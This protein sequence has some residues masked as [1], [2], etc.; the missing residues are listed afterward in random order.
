ME[1]ST[2]SL[3]R[4]LIL[5]P[6]LAPKGLDSLVP[7]YKAFMTI[8]SMLAL[9]MVL[10][11]SVFRLHGK[12]RIS[13]PYFGLIS[14]FLVA[15]VVSAFSAKGI[16]NGLQELFFFPAAF[17]YLIELDQ[18]EFR[19]YCVASAYILC[20]LFLAE[21]VVPASLFAGKY[22]LTFLGHVQVFSQYGLLAFTLACFIYLKNWASSFV[23][24]ILATLGLISMLIV[25]ADSAHLCIIVFGIV[26]LIKS[27]LP[28]DWRIDFRL[29]V[30]LS[31]I[32]SGFLVWITV[33]RT[34]PLIGTGL[35]WT[36]N[37]RLFVWESANNLIKDSF[38]FGY[39][40]E[41]SVITTF[42]S[43]G[44][45]YAH[46]QVVQCLVDG[47]VVLLIA[48]VWMLCSVARCVNYISDNK[49]RSV[50]VAVLCALLFVLIFDSF[51][52]YSYVYILLALVSREGL[53]S[54]DGANYEV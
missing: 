27:A 10:L 9:A 26:M 53:L 44:M 18:A 31:I 35:D 42:W 15:F 4:Y 24:I 11:D 43:S 6:L 30:V 16:V 2:T 50:S 17:L 54:R 47:G 29:V 25:D 8:W 21:L 20:A 52:P 12:K 45:S 38:L 19:E 5:I 39:G 51:T 7:G 3:L 34:S 41:N 23:A 14:Y 1:R 13:A 33:A 28:S 32:V 37:G 46:N 40:V 36:F 49:V 22:H 48:M